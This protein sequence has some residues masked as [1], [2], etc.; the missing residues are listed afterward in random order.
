MESGNIQRKGTTAM[1][2]LIWLVIASNMADPHAASE[3]HKVR[4]T[5]VT[6]LSSGSLLPVVTLPEL[7]REYRKPHKAKSNTSAT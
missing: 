5:I 1:S 2:V 6:G 4:S 7:L 3:T